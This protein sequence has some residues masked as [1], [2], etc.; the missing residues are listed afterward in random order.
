MAV[1]V[2]VAKVTPGRS[3]V[4]DII[5]TDH[6]FVSFAMRN[7]AVSTAGKVDMADE[8]RQLKPP[9]TIRHGGI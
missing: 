2:A 1:F 4:R 6:L 7:I 9:L 5:K 8:R 3:V